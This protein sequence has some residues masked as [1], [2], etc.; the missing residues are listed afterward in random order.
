MRGTQA[1]QTPAQIR[2]GVDANY[3]TTHGMS[4]PRPPGP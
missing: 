4:I 1:G 2:A 3:G